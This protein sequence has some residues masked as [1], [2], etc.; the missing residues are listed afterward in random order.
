MSFTRLQWAKDLCQQAG[1]TNPSPKLLAFIVGWSKHETNT[2]SGARFNLLNT[3]LNGIEGSTNFNSVGVKNFPNYQSGLN[4]TLITLKG[5]YY[6]HIEEGIRDNVE[7][8]FTD[9]PDAEI[10]K[11]LHTW[12]G[13]ENGYA[14]GLVSLGASCLNDIFDYGTSPYNHPP[15]AFLP[16]PVQIDEANERWKSLVEDAPIGTGIYNSWIDRW[17][18][19][20]QVMGPPTGHERSGHNWQGKPIVY[21]QFLH[22]TCEWDGSAHWFDGRGPID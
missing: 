4:A 1:N 9:T 13:D 17:C 18:Q 3:T 14:S 20:M 6:P 16:S 11:E 8:F 21:Q 12:S 7:S 22:A 10:V 2:N 15:T 5:G 19:K